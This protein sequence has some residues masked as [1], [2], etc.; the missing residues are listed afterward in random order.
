MRKSSGCVCE[1]MGDGGG[2]EGG[3]DGKTGDGGGEEERCGKNG[4]GNEELGRWRRR[5]RDRGILR[6]VAKR[7]RRRRLKKTGEGS[8]EMG[9]GVS[10]ARIHE[11]SYLRCGGNAE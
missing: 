1:E 5:R 9:D 6:E 8:L 4:E 3:S 7:W 2:E 10:R 11:H